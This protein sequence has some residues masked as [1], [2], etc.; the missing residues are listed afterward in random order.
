MLKPGLMPS[1]CGWECEDLRADAVRE[2]Q[3]PQPRY[4]TARE[5][6]D[7]SL[8]VAIARAPRKRSC[9]A[10]V[11]TRIVD[12]RSRQVEGLMKGHVSATVKLG[13]RRFRAGFAGF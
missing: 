7:Q 8:S 1:I 9:R 12:S 2:T 10:G 4:E 13:R 11:W 5:T 6:S 3:Q